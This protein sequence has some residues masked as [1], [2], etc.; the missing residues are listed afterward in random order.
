MRSLMAAALAACI[1]ATPGTAGASTQQQREQFIQ[2]YINRHTETPK[3]PWATPNRIR[4]SDGFAHEPVLAREAA[5]KFV[6][7]HGY[8]TWPKPSPVVVHEVTISGVL[9]SVH[10]APA[11]PPSGSVSEIICSVFGPYCSEAISVASCESG[12]NPAAV[13]GQYLGLFQ[14]GEY[15]RSTYGH[16]PDA[17]TQSRAAFAYFTDTGRTWAPWSCKP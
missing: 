8:V 6:L 14:M 16:G 4:V 7:T 12:L 5:I 15:A 17:L 13:N 3:E 11:P 1:I 2:S 9:E 10:T